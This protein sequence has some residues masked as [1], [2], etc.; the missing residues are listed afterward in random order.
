[1]DFRKF[2][3]K[4]ITYGQAR[5]SRCFFWKANSTMEATKGYNRD[6]TKAKIKFVVPRDPLIGLK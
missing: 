2:C 1:M 5:N 6:Q 4:G 3:V